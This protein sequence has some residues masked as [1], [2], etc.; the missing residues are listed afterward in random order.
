[1]LSVV[2]KWLVNPALPSAGLGGAGSPAVRAAA[3][4]SVVGGIVTETES[5]NSNGTNDTRASAQFLK[6]FGTGVSN[7]AAIDVGGALGPVGPAITPRE[8]DGSITLAN[9]TALT[10]GTVGRTVAN[11]VIGDGPNGSGGTKTGDYDYYRISAA[12]D[13]LLTVNVDAGAGALNPVVGIYDSAGSLL[14][15]NDDEYSGTAYGSTLNSYLRFLTP[16]SGSYFVVVFG[17][18]SGPQSNPFNSASG[19]GAA[20]E[21]AYELTVVME[22]PTIVHPHED[23]G[24]I[25]LASDTGIPLGAG[26]IAY[27]SGSVGDG[28]HGSGGDATGDF[29]FY[30][31]Q[32]VAGQTITADIDGGVAPA[33]PNG[34]DTYVGIY[35]SNGNLLATRDD[36]GK[37]YN[38]LL[39]FTAP[40]TGTYYI[41]VGGYSGLGTE[42][43]SNPLDSSS[44]PG[45]GVEGDYTLAIRVTG[46]GDVDFYS[47]DLSGGDVFSAALSGHAGHMEL[48]QSDG[49]LLM[50]S[51]QNDNALK[52]DVSPLP[53]GAVSI[54]RVVNTPGRYFLAVSGGIGSYT[55]KL[56]DFRPALES[57]PVYSHQILFLDFNGAALNAQETFRNQFFGAGN[58]DARLSPMSAFLPAW[59]LSASDENGV[60]DAVVARVVHA[61]AQNISGVVGHGLNGDFTITNHAGDFQIEILNSRDNPDPWGIYPNVS[62]VI[63]GGTLAEIGAPFFFDGMSQSIDVGNFA[64]AETAVAVLDSLSAPADYTDPYLG[65]LNSVPRA[66]GVSMVSL[67][68]NILG[69]LASHEAGHMFG[70]YHVEHGNNNLM[71][72]YS[73]GELGP[74]GLWGNADDPDFEFK[75]DIYSPPEG[76]IGIEDTLNTIAYDLSTGKRA[77]TYFDFTTGT[78]YV[79]GSIDD[80]RKDSLQVKTAGANLQVYINGQIALTRP[81]AGVRRVFLNGSDDSDVLDASAYAGP[82]T[83]EGRGGDDVLIA[84]TGPAI[85][86]GDGGNDRLFG[87]PANDILVGGDGHDALDGGAGSDLLIGGRDTDLLYGGGAGDLLIG[88]RTAYDANAD[89]LTAILSEWSSARPYVTRIDNLRG[90]GT[91]PRNNGNFFLKTSGAQASV[92]D[93]A[94]IDILTGGPGRDWFFATTGRKNGDLILALSPDESADR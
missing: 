73:F 29:D 69:S 94:S 53:L 75:T 10:A 74:D 20:S 92:F 93:D 34:L 87:G 90:V 81:S 24:S 42:L 30:K 86:F 61:L 89:A 11:G 52:P 78:L 66:P 7:V 62:R 3:K 56:R 23:D 6:N 38:S 83:L 39:S 85:L 40:S 57:Q 43:P 31:V 54:A 15:V 32:A 26:G 50:G 41:A 22:S 70:N 12:T 16:A 4:S 2:G 59:G 51:S 44:G 47:F 33:T 46:K 84:G 80:G 5:A 19:G 36:D 17:S 91:L 14:A 9:A 21:G 49:T 88:G 28:P 25:P 65:S 68:G 77:G 71:D 79:S 1:M 63:I 35:D 13:Q 27:A 45:V 82:A 8:D 48:Y 72:P 67:V 58:P 60:I 76:D 18:G 64:T 55:L 37:T